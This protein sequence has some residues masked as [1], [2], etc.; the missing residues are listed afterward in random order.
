MAT[1]IENAWPVART[2]HRCDVCSGFIGAGERYNRQRFV[3]D[4]EPGTYKAHA[5]C[6][7]A[8]WIAWRE[9]ELFDDESPDFDADVRPLL[10]AFFMSLTGWDAT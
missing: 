2:T 6:D 9:L 10:E 1:L 3:W 5:L 4:G 8:Y 7:A